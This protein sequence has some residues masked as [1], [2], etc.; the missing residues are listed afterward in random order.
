MEMI[1]IIKKEHE[2]IKRLLI[3]LKSFIDGNFN[4][5]EF[6]QVF[7]EFIRFWSNHEKKE[8]EFFSKIGNFDLASKMNFE[9]K[10]NRGY[11]KVISMALETHY[12]PYIKVTLDIDGK[13]M[14]NRLTEHM[15]KEEELLNKLEHKM[16]IS[17]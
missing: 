11:K 5:Q 15:R 1:T 4:F 8:E 2:E 17:N 12:E 6:T 3:E 10:A 13:M 7:K 9:H 14:I 16:I